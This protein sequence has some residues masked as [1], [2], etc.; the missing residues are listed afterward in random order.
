VRREDNSQE[1]LD[2]KKSIQYKRP[3]FGPRSRLSQASSRVIKEFMSMDAEYGG[4]KLAGSRFTMLDG[5]EREE[6]KLKRAFANVLLPEPAG[7]T[8]KIISIIRGLCLFLQLKKGIAKFLIESL[9]DI[10]IDEILID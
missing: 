8:I 2:S 9:I 5:M 1:M 6:R 4:E 10:F 7:P 3:P